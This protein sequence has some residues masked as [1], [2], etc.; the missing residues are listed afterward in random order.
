MLKD[1]DIY[2]T[3]VFSYLSRVY[4]PESLTSSLRK[5]LDHKDEKIMISEKSVKNIDIFPD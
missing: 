1:H 4:N 2:N 3:F 5:K